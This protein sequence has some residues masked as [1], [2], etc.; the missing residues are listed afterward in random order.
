MY[1]FPPPLTC[2]ITRLHQ[3]AHGSSCFLASPGRTLFTKLFYG[4]P[5][6]DRFL[7]FL[8]PPF[9][10][11]YHPIS[12]R[13]LRLWTTASR[14]FFPSVISS[15][16]K[17]PI[18]DNASVEPLGPRLVVLFFGSGF[19]LVVQSFG[20]YFFFPIPPHMSASMNPV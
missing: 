10:S 16:F 5:P 7:P 9:N 4:R 14:H 17:S 8:P 11:A 19:L 3:Y 18:S 6:L 20:L 2:R 12:Q 15:F 1:F 13:S